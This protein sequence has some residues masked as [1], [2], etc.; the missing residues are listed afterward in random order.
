[1]RSTKP[2]LSALEYLESVFHGERLG[3]ALF[4]V[5]TSFDKIRDVLGDEGRVF[6]F[7]LV[8]WGRWPV[9]AEVSRDPSDWVPECHSFSTGVYDFGLF[10]GGFDGVF[11]VVSCVEN[12]GNVECSCF[13]LWKVRAGSKGETIRCGTG[14]AATRD[15]TQEGTHL[16]IGT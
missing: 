1:V 8:P 2:F 14:T 9:S 4:V 10:A 7:G 13:M 15:P 3:F 12:R 5:F 16:V 6:G 11:L